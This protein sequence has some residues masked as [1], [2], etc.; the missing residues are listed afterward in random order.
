MF[1]KLS[2]EIK[3]ITQFAVKEI[4]QL[5]LNSYNSNQNG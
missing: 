4:K 2:W 3:L 1:Y 5:I